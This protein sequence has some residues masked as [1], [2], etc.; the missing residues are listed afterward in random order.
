MPDSKKTDEHLVVIPDR[1]SRPAAVFEF[2][3]RRYT[4]SSLGKGFLT[5][6]LVAGSAAGLVTTCFAVF[7]LRIA[8][9]DQEGIK[10][11]AVAI[12]KKD[13][14]A[15]IQRDQLMATQDTM[16][17]Q[18]RELQEQGALTGLVSCALVPSD[19]PQWLQAKCD[20]VLRKGRS[21]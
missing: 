2:Y 18:I 16:K 19:A 21:R 15:S 6:C 11:L 13:S 17:V 14:I 4:L 9:I 10:T 7:G 3:G 20:E 12:A 5:F 8:N 1:R